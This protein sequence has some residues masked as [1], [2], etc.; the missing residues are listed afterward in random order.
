M[1]D[2]DYGDA[3]LTGDLESDLTAAPRHVSL[4]KVP[5]HGSAN[6]RLRTSARL[7]VVSVGANNTFGHPHPST[8]PALR[9]DVLGAI[10]VELGPDGPAVTS[11][12][13]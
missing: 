1:L 5:H 12:L 7:R 3:L 13:R 10:R 11:P 9:T 8:M 6:A 4:L 2:T